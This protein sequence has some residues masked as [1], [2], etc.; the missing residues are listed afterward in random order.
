MSVPVYKRGQSSVQF[1]EIA[2]ELH[3]ESVRFGSSLPK[4]ARLTL[5]VPIADSATRI[6]R[7]VHE[8]NHIHPDSEEFITERKRDLWAVLGELETLQILV[9][10]ALSIYS[11]NTKSKKPGETVGD[12]ATIK[13]GQKITEERKLINGLLKSDK[14]K[15]SSLPEI[16]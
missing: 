10:N 1:I 11:F 16:K 7:L 3:L 6:L 8:A 14:E 12:I 5:T 2:A 4:A 13:I 9:I 15:E